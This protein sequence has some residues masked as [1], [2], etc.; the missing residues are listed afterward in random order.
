MNKYV[1]SAMYK[2]RII[3]VSRLKC[4]TCFFFGLNNSPKPTTAV[5]IMVMN[6]DNK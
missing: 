1:I 2:S 4:H 3:N 5:I 6:T